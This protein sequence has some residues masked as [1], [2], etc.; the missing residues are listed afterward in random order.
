VWLW[1]PYGFNSLKKSKAKIKCYNCPFK[2]VVKFML[3]A[4]SVCV[5]SFFAPNQSEPKWLRFGPVFA[6]IPL[7]NVENFRACY[8]R[9]RICFLCTWS[10]RCDKQVSIHLYIC[11]WAFPNMSPFLCK[12]CPQGLPIPYELFLKSLDYS[13]GAGKKINNL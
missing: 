6:K 5:H 7:E 12:Q 13:L 2:Y 11:I 10:K 1:G 4:C 3:Y 9:F 8:A